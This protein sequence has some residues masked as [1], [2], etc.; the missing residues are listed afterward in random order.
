MNFKKQSQ[1]QPQ[2]RPKTRVKIKQAIA[3]NREPMYDLLDFSFGPG[4]VVEIDERLAANW[5][6]S[7]IAEAVN[8]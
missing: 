3:G 8:P 6:A 1:S 7:G 4:Q 2:P 5:I